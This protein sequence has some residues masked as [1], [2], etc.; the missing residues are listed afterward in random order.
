M[1]R[2][3]LGKGKRFGFFY[4]FFS[5]YFSVK[6]IDFNLGA[7]KTKGVRHERFVHVLDVSFG[8]EKATFTR[9]DS[10]ARR[11]AIF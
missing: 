3:H 1:S 9:F 7:G 5:W 6:K 4:V 11:D 10:S 2:L 8:P